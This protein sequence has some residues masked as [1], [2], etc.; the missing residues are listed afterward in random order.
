MSKDV[1]NT[2]IVQTIMTLAH[3]LGVTVVAEGVETVEQLE[4]LR[5]LNV[6]TAEAI[7]SP[8]RL[9]ARAPSLCFG[10]PCHGND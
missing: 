1:G 8:I 9:T 10:A 3:N 6:N 2:E 7:C 5:S 4:Q